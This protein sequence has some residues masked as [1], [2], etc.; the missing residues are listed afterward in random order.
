M[1]IK[2]NIV[3]IGKPGEITLKDLAK[4]TPFVSS[5]LS[6]QPYQSHNSEFNLQ[7]NR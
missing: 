1:T 7:E 2:F 3:E 5:M 6:G 4:D